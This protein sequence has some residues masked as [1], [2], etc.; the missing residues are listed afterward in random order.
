VAYSNSVVLERLASF[1]SLIEAQSAHAQMIPDGS[2]TYASSWL[3]ALR[4][5][6]D[7]LGLPGRS[8][9]IGTTHVGI[10]VHHGSI[11]LLPLAFSDPLKASKTCADLYHELSTDLPDVPIL[12][13]RLPWKIA[14]PLLLTEQF[15]IANHNLSDWILEDDSFPEL[16]VM[17][18]RLG[19]AHALARG[20]R[21]FAR[22][23][24]EV[25]L[26]RDGVSA[27]K[28]RTV[29]R[30]ICGSDHDKFCAYRAIVDE[31]FHPSRRAD[32]LTWLFQ[33]SDPPHRYRG[34]YV[35]DSLG[36]KTAGLYCAVS[37]R[38][39]GGLTEWMDMKVLCEMAARGFDRVLLGGSETSGVFAYTQKLLPVP[40]SSPGIT[41][42]RRDTVGRIRQVARGG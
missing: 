11:S 7:E 36:A 2:P 23:G 16:E 38:D 6:R 27:T 37:S 19:D 34:L 41:I 24:V 39:V 25:A 42:V 5:C 33:D 30:T 13:K 20:V 15:V 40:A 4:V 32:Y 31:A 29:L 35:V 22:R 28:A 17:T 10:G 1:P 9:H 21:R 14:Q 8:G 3:Y 18:D 12:L 26:C